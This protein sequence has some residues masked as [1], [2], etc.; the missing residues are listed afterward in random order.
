MTVASSSGLLPRL[1]RALRPVSRTV[2]PCAVACPG[3][4]QTWHGWRKERHQV[5]SCPRCQHP[6]FLLPSSPFVPGAAGDAATAEKR[7]RSFWVMPALAGAGTLLLLALLVLAVLPYLPRRDASSTEPSRKIETRI[8]SGRTALAGGGFH[9]AAVELGE[10]CKQL[11]K[12]PGLLSPARHREVEQWYC[13]ADLLDRLLSQSLQELLHQAQAAG[14]E[15]EWRVRFQSDYQGKTVVFD[16]LLRRDA[17]GRPQLS[18]TA[19]RSGEVEGAWHWRKSGC[20][21][22]CRWFSRSACCSGPSW[23]ALLANR[24]ATGSSASSPTAACC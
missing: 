4:G 1:W 16:D 23:P 12:Q 6:L 17:E 3:C 5:V 13:Q 8:E 7:R 9:Q 2:V 14:R 24:A 22:G 15:E 19:V 10:V 20:W 21:I 11:R 18:F